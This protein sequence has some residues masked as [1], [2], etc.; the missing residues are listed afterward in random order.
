MGKFAIYEVDMARK[1]K[2][3]APEFDT[4]EAAYG[5]AVEKFAKV[6][7]FI[8]KDEDN[9]AYDFITTIGGVYAIEAA[10]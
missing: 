1:R 3:D 7:A 6:M 4:L 2:I 8:E 5:F 9:E 10:A